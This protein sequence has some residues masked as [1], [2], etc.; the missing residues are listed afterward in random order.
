MIED[1]KVYFALENNYC[2][3]YVTEKFQNALMGFAI[4]IVNGWRSSY[5]ELLPGSYIH[6]DD[7]KH[8][9]SKLANHIDYLLTNETA[10]FEYHK[11]R[12][13]LEVFGWNHDRNLQCQMCT[14]VQHFKQHFTQAHT[15]QPTTIPDVIDH[16]H[17]MQK[18]RKASQFDLKDKFGQ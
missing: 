2:D 18:C 4:P 15:Y 10:F 12:T 17:H 16:F 5:D 9:L 6:V 13:E 8:D 1:C 3:G 7:Y 11:W 14:K